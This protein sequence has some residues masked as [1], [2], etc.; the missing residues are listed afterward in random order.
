LR[1][2][3]NNS[4]LNQSFVVPVLLLVSVIIA[5]YYPTILSGIHPYDDPGILSRYSVSLPL[6]QVL[7]PGNGYY[8]R[9]IIE[10][11]FWL[12]N[13]LWGMEAATMHMENIL[14]HGA[15]SLL[16]FFLARKIFRE[17]GIPLISLLAAFLFALHPVNVEA[18]AWIAGR[19]DPLLTL[20]VLSSL[21]FWLRWF[22][23]PRW[24]D[25]VAAL[26]L[27]GAAL[28]TKETAIA[29]GA[30]VVLFV[31]V[32]PG[33]ATLRQRILA[34]ALMVLPVVL[35]VIVVL[36]FQN[37]TSGLSRFLTD[38]NLQVVPGIRGGLVAFGFY[39]KKLIIPFPL[40]FAI[41][42]VDPAYALIGLVLLPF[43][44]W[45]MHCHRRAGIFFI[46]ALLFILPAVLVA[47]KQVAWTPFAE[48]YLYLPSAFFMLGLS[49]CVSDLCSNHKKIMFLTALCLACFFAVI[50]VQRTLLWNDKSAFFQDAIDKSPGFG[51]VYYTLGGILA[52]KGE[53]NRAYEAFLTAERLNQRDSMRYPI[54]AAI[55]GTKIIKGE[56][57]EARG[58]FFEIFT[59]K[60]HASADFLELLFKADN[61]RLV[62][63]IGSQKNILAADILETLNLL[64]QK[65]P[66]PFWLYQSGQ[67]ALITDDETK[68][69]DFFHRAYTSAPA[70]AHYRG[71]ALTYLRRLEQ[72]K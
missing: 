70:D 8:Y 13:R 52:Q 43:V 20:F 56:L 39:A 58:Y 62:K 6:L 15:N 50:S 3:L 57:L 21:F 30:V 46:S 53:I 32:W 26:L 11:S 23:R 25:M 67:M 29:F 27:F 5:V 54:K 45:L 28:L 18:V 61:K 22:S 2:W 4:Q 44:W 40:N 42:E 48:R 68:A 12:D 66:D 49:A 55:M 16:I 7:L 34:A 31:F 19:T 33:E 47:V 14:L 38:T 35:L 60:E 37:G 24:Q 17:D 71:A 64:H 1:S 51:S 69:A 63:L 41:D 59:K 36:L 72:S 10:L 9:P 65:R